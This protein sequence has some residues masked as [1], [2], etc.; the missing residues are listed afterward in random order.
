MAIK[1]DSSSIFKIRKNLPTG[2]SSALLR[3]DRKTL[4]GI[5]EIRMRADGICSVTNE[6]GNIC[7]CDTGLTKNTKL[8]LKVSREE[9]E[10]F[11]Y[12][13]CKGSVYSYED[14][15]SKFY[16]TSEGFRVGLAGECICE[17]GKIKSIGKITSVNIRI[18]HH[19]PGCSD[20]LFSKIK[21]NMFSDGGGILIISAPGVG[22]TTLLRD[23][24][25]SLSKSCDDVDSFSPYR[26]CVIDERHEI[27]AD[28][29]FSQCHIDFL[30]GI[31]KT[32][33]IEIASRVLS[34]QI[35]ICDEISSPEEAEKITRQKN[36]GTVFI[37]SMHADS[38]E[39]IMKKDYVRKMFQNGVFSHTYLLKRNGREVS[40]TLY[41]YEDA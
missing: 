12:R 18:P 20:E 19:V 27:Y 6:Y 9:T 39:G 36:G 7:L 32:S 16:I 17:G 1:C 22:K 24:A 25:V 14:T 11:I 15:L 37:A 33:G 21:E 5:F 29:I 2:V 34:A 8:S 26:V 40:G 30:S 41:K 13:L 3:L 35:I 31:D 10:E 38:Y 28:E 23:L 4:S